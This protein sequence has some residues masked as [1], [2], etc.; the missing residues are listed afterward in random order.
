MSLPLQC[1]SHFAEEITGGQTEQ[2][3]PTSNMHPGR[4]GRKTYNE[5]T[6]KHINERTLVNDDQL[7]RVLRARVTGES[8]G[9]SVGR[10]LN[11][12]GCDIHIIL[13]KD[14]G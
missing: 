3:R 12:D 5:N 7:S 13:Q 14:I 9:A 4:E 2:V 1:P 11:E 6:V 10:V 8:P